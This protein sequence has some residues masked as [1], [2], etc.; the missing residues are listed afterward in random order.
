MT[1]FLT[2]TGNEQK[3]IEGRVVGVTVIIVCGWGWKLS[4]AA[5]PPAGEPTWGVGGGVERG[6]ADDG[7]VVEGRFRRIFGRYF[8]KMAMA[9]SVASG[10]GLS[11][12]EDDTK[13]SL[14]LFT[15]V[16]VIVGVSSVFST[17]GAVEVVVGVSK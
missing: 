12:V 9:F 8:I 2:A 16:V 1:A 15:T 4:W 11:Q 6:H 5:S 3:V 17:T 7:T 10:T 13:G 14:T